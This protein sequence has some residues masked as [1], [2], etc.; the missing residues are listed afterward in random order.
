MDLEH[1]LENNSTKIHLLPVDQ[2]HTKK[3]YT[4]QKEKI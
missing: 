3:L 4:K 2:Y 1:D